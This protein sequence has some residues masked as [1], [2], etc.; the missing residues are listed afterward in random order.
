MANMSQSLGNLRRSAWCL[1]PRPA[2]DWLGR[3][4]DA[5]MAILVEY[6]KAKAAEET[7]QRLIAMSARDLTRLGT[8]RDQIATHI[9]ESLYSNDSS[10]R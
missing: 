4:R 8:R 10:L 2:I 9:R 6:R 5:V 1:D 3:H 7:Y